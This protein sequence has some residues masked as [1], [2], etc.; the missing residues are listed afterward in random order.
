MPLPADADIPFILS[1]IRPDAEWGWAGGSY[2]DP[3]NLD[4]RDS[5]QIEPTEL[6]LE[7]EWDVI[8]VE[9]A[10]QSTVKQQL[11]SES[12]STVGVLLSSLTNAQSR[13]LLEMILYAL[14]G[15]KGAFQAMK[16]NCKQGGERRERSRFLFWPRRAR[17]CN[18][19]LEMRWLTFATWTEAYIPGLGW[20]AENWVDKNE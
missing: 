6:E 12:A 9:Q 5:V 19:R 13:V 15:S 10:S 2:A 4:W 16:F 3:Q 20:E 18:R 17:N 11:V 7:T 1:R 8:L 14:G